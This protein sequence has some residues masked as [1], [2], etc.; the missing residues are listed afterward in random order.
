MAI[1]SYVRQILL[2][3]HRRRIAGD[4]GSGGWGFAFAHVGREKIKSVNGKAVGG[5]E[6]AGK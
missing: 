6:S 5:N 4:G 1:M 2:P 3:V